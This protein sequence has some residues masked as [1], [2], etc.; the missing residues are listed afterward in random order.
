MQ[1]IEFA[2]LRELE[3]LMS[4]QW[5]ADRYQ[6]VDDLMANQWAQLPNCERVSQGVFYCRR[7][8]IWS[9]VS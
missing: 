7:C 3:R 5:F 1:A 4:C 8:M 9:R 2:S 6:Y